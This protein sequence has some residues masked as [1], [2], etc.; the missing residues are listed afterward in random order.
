MLRAGGGDAGAFRR[1]LA[2]PVPGV[3][4]YAQEQPYRTIVA[5]LIEI[6]GRPYSE[7]FLLKRTAPARQSLV[8]PGRMPGLPSVAGKMIASRASRP[9][10]DTGAFDIDL[11]A[12]SGIKADTDSQARF[13]PS[14]SRIRRYWRHGKESPKAKLKSPTNSSISALSTT[15]R[16]KALLIHEPGDP[17]NLKGYVHIPR[18]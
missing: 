15:V 9:G 17:H 6:P 14:R 1:I 18:E 3:R 8:R 10:A 5:D 12:P 11:N 2:P 13:T 4:E 16:W 7:L